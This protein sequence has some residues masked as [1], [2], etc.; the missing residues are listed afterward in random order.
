MRLR[1]FL[2]QLRILLLSALVLMVQPLLAQT[3]EK[4]QIGTISAQQLLGKAA[5]LIAG[6][7]INFSGMS[8]DSSSN[9]SITLEKFEILDPESH[10][11]VYDASGQTK[12]QLEPRHYFKGTV[13]GESNSFVFCYDCL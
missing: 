10:A 9:S 8:I 5:T 7:K 3:P 11:M 4:I 13:D 6:Q 1:P 12:R 2:Q